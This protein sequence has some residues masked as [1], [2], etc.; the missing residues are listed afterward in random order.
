MQT[1]T[2]IVE[3]MLNPESYPEPTGKIDLIQ[4]HISFVFITQNYV[5]KVKKPVNFG[6]LDFSTLEKRRIY[7]QKE[8]E[9]NKR[10]CPEIY[11]QVVPI[12]KAQTLKID[13]EGEAVEYALKMKKLPQDR[14]MTQLLQE[15][16][17]DKKVIDEIARIVAKFH[18][19]AQT[20][21]EISQFGELGTV[22]TNWAE[23]FSQTI[24]YIGQ[25][26]S[27]TDYN[28]IQSKIN[29]FMEQNNLL[30][31][32]RID[33]RH[34]RDCHGDLHSGN[35]FVT[36]KIYIFDAIEFNDRFR[37]SDVASDVAFLAMD[38]DYQERSDLSDYFIAKYI[39]YS[40][41][42]QI[43]LMLPFYKCYRA[44]VR[45]KVV[46]FRLDDSN[47]TAEQKEA[48]IKEA[49]GYF[50]LATNYAKYL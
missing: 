45:G 3:A 28:L 37:Y 35:I 40:N 24:K 8:L 29:K 14:I 16:K 6:F 42:A 15:G 41:D 48:A 33:G 9:L 49:S 46:S 39:T 23:N 30:F 4:T 17:V 7:C 31:K 11:L 12:T 26:V 44:Y 20:N 25:S 27:R 47:I 10:L 32:G 5:Y 19:E 2:P 22:K 38:L 36:D 21:D 43:S 18:S 13:G 34:I 1:K 50:R